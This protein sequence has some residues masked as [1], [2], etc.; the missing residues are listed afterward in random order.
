MNQELITLLEAIYSLEEEK[1]TR[2]ILD[3]WVTPQEIVARLAQVQFPNANLPWVRT[4]LNQLWIARKILIVPTEAV[5][6]ISFADVELIGLDRHQTNDGKIRLEANDVRGVDTVYQQVAIL[7]ERTSIKIRSR[8]AEIGRLLSQNYLR[9]GMAPATGVIRYERRQQKRPRRTLVIAEVRNNWRTQILAGEIEVATP[10]QTRRYKLRASA[11]RQQLVQATEAVTQALEQRLGPGRD[12]LAGF[13]VASVAATLAGLYSDE[14]RQSHEAHV[15]TAGVGSG[16]SFAFQLGALIHTTACALLGLSGL[17]VLL[18]YPRVVLAANQFQELRELVQKTGEILGVDLKQPLLDAGSQLTQ[19]LGIGE[20]PGALFQAMQQ[21]YG[22]GQYPIIISNL[23]TLANRLTHP[24]ASR[25]LVENLDLIVCDELH[26]L[27]GLYGSHSRMLLKRLSLLRSVW[28]L[29]RLNPDDPFEV[30]LNRRGQIRSAYFVGASATIAAPKKHLGRLFEI[31]ED[32]VLAIDV[33]DVQDTGWVHHFFLRQRP[34]VSTMSA[35]VNATSALIHNR[36]DGVFRE[37][38]QQDVDHGAQQSLGMDQLA[39]PIQGAPGGTIK[40]K[41]PEFIHKTLGFCDSLDG[42]GRWADLVADNEGTKAKGVVFPNPGNPDAYPYFSRFAEPLWRQVHQKSFAAKPEKWI[43]VVRNHYGSLCRRCKK[44]EPCT[45]SRIPGGLTTAGQQELD[46][47]WNF[48]PTNTNSYLSRLGVSADN[49]G[50]AWLAPVRNAAQEA[51]LSNL[52]KCPFL[53]AGLC[54]W[55]SMDHAGSNAP[56][57]P[58][59]NTPLNGVR[60][61]G[62]RQDHRHHFINGVRLSRFTSETKSDMLALDTINDIFK[63]PAPQVLRDMSYPPAQIENSVFV[64][65]SPRLEVGVDLSRVRDGVTYRAMKDPASLQQKVGRVGRELQSDSV[66]VHLVTQNTR[67]QYYF[68]NPQIALDPQYLQALPLHEDNRIVARHHFFMAIVDF[69]SLQGTGPQNGRIAANGDRISLVNDHAQGNAFSGW[70]L[71]VRGAYNFL[72]GQHNRQQQN[73]ENL[74]RYLRALGA[75]QADLSQAN[76]AALLTPAVSPMSQP[77]G[78]IDLFKHEFGPNF[79]ITEL[80][81]PGGGTFTLAWAVTQ[82]MVPHDAVNIAFPR[83]REFLRQINAEQAQ[84]GGKPVQYRSYLRDILGQPLFRRGL[85]S[86]GMRGNHPF[87]WTPNFFQSVGVETVRVVEMGGQQARERGYESVSLALALLPPGTVTYRYSSTPLK[88]PV[89]AH[90]AVAQPNLMGNLLQMV[91]LRTDV[92]DYFEVAEA[93]PDI[94][95]ADL[96]PDFVGFGPVKVFTPRQIPL[97]RSESEPRVLPRDMGE[98]LLVDGD[99]RPVPQGKQFAATF[100]L[101]QPPRSFALR[102]YRLKS[103]QERTGIVSRFQRLLSLYANNP[104]PF[105]WPPVYSM[106]SKM[107]FDPHLE[108]TDFVWGL[109]RQFTSRQVDPARLVYWRQTEDNT[110]VPMAL[111]HRFTAPALIFNLDTSGQSTVSTFIQE[112]LTQPGSVVYQ[113]VLVQTLERF[114]A[115]RGRVAGDGWFATPRPSVFVIRNLR[116]IVLFHLLDRWCPNAG[117]PPQNPPVFSLADVAGCFDQNHPNWISPERFAQICAEISPIQEAPS[118]ITHRQ[119]L[120]STRANFEAAAAHAASFDEDFFKRAA[121]DLLLN[122][123][124]LALHAAALR[125]SGAER[126][127]LGYFYHAGENRAEILLFDRDAFGN[128][129]VELVRDHFFVPNAQRALCTRLRMLG[130]QPDPLPTKD[131]ARCFE[132]EL[133]EC[134]SSQSAHLAFHNHTPQSPCWDH[135]SSEFQGERRRA[136]PLYDFL[137]AQMA[138]TSFDHLAVLQACPEFV[139]FLSS[140]RGTPLVGSPDFP[141]FQALES[142]FGF[143]MSGCIGCLVAPETN[144][145]GSLEARETVNKVLLDAFYRRT[146]CEANSNASAVCYPGTGPSR[147][148]AC[149]EWTAV[150]ATALAQDAA[151]IS[152]SLMLPAGD[153]SEQMVSLV[154]PLVTRG[155]NPVVFRTSWNAGT[156]PQPRVRVRMDF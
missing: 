59:E 2:G 136:G 113:S 126:E 46:S 110:P 4:Q 50:A 64:I 106:F 83:H 15:I 99:S 65:G 42:V 37:Y 92:A 1:L 137:R 49:V 43:G 104:P 79:F 131:F 82:P 19:Q 88:V 147:T 84:G 34:E 22:T 25:G 39:N 141:G 112:V 62:P 33:S 63:G 30:L 156:V 116:T 122:S 120:L 26:L 54:W 135:L 87:V 117:V 140:E 10:E 47:L 72:F 17:R 45:I 151:P 48:A 124:G 18:I 100:T 74:N 123:L 6:V 29:R 20:V 60:M 67:D 8:V 16:K 146:I 150:L 35:L 90:H 152:V 51:D 44:G 76:A 97:I 109:D 61:A 145:H 143:C 66:L 155:A 105:P 81:R 125:L 148:C 5:E 102:W 28:Q 93:C 108:I 69:L 119:T 11:P 21:A 57:P 103:S 85:P 127:N 95:T 118:E 133:N 3:S 12:K 80:P 73:L 138:I 101:P 98:G 53:Q 14:Y 132:E 154:S 130:Q 23:D 121:L 31:A 58:T 128:G 7:P 38:Y 68:R 36:R 9:F 13:Q 139:A 144:L 56:A 129:T 107:D 115:E 134:G 111:G 52:D 94:D 153:G 32:R 142:A 96:P 91:V 78:A 77:V 70:D 114:I 89:G 75:T 86:V 27:A 55:W 24:E 40:P 41:A 71:K 149:H